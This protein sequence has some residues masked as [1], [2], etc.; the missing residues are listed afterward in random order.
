[1]YTRV[2]VLLVHLYIYIY[3]YLSY[4]ALTS[5]SHHYHY[6]H[7]YH[8]SEFHFGENM[9]P[10]NQYVIPTNQRW[11]TTVSVTSLEANSG[12]SQ[13]GLNYR[14]LRPSPPGGARTVMPYRGLQ[15]NG[16]SDLTLQLTAFQKYVY[17]HMYMYM[18]MYMYISTSLTHSH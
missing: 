17:M 5:F 2:C 15:N 18:Y 12:S 3:V 6:Y 1:M 16:S 4:L 10:A 11:S 14:G 7:Y 9:R 8:Y 13:A